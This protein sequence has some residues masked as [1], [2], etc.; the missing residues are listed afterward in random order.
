MARISDFRLIV[1]GPRDQVDC[2]KQKIL[3]DTEPIAKGPFSDEFIFDLKPE[4]WGDLEDSQEF[5][6]LKEVKLYVGQSVLGNC[7]PLHDELRII[8]EAK[9]APP[10]VFAQRILEMFLE[11]D[12][13][14]YATTNHELYEHWQSRRYEQQLVCRRE[15]LTDTQD[16]IILRL[17]IDGHQILPRGEDQSD[18]GDLD[19]EPCVHLYQFDELES[20][21]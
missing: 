2:L 21:D 7:L 15:Q 20:S 6:W 8:G 9:Y 17:I 10:L 1:C 4:T 3:A 11:L 16:D 12:I 13:D 14:L 5:L 19:E 18:T